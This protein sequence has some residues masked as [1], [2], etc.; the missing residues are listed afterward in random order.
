MESSLLKDASFK[1]LPGPVRHRMLIGDR[2]LNATVPVQAHHVLS[3]YLNYKI[4]TKYQR[5]FKYLEPR[6]PMMEKNCKSE[7][8]NK[9]LVS[10]FSYFDPWF[11]NNASPST[12]HPSLMQLEHEHFRHTRQ[13]L[14]PM[15]WK[16]SIDHNCFCRLC[17]TSNHIF[18]QCFQSWGKFDQ[19]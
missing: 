3:S 7:G 1:G 4:P 16:T 14:F 5:T 12:F 13:P 18:S 19:R 8:N 10:I 15:S 17:L 9:Q 6:K 2:N 11:L